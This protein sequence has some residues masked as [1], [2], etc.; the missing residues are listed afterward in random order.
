MIA[1]TVGYIVVLCMLVASVSAYYT[2]ELG[3]FYTSSESITRDQFVASAGSYEACG[4]EQRIIPLWIV[5]KENAKQFRFSLEDAPFASLSGSS[6]TLQP[7]QQGVI[8][9]ILNPSVDASGSAPFYLN[10]NTNGKQTLHHRID[11]VLDQCYGVAVDIESPETILCSCEETTFPVKITNTGSSS[12]SFKVDLNA[13]DFVSIDGDTQAIAAHNTTQNEVIVTPSCDD[14]GSYIIKAIAELERSSSVQGQD[15]IL[16]KI[17]S[18]ESCYNAN[19]DAYNIHAQY[20]KSFQSVTIK[21]SGLKEATYSLSLDA[22]DWIT[23]DTESLRLLPGQIK[24]VTLE[25]NPPSEI[26]AGDYPAKITASTGD[27]VFEEVFTIGLRQETSFLQQV[28]SFLDYYRYYIYIALSLAL[29]GIIL[30]L[31]KRT[32]GTRTEKKKSE[33]MPEIKKKLPQKKKMPTTSRFYISAAIL[34]LG[35]F[36]VYA[37]VRYFDVLKS[38]AK[39]Y[40]GYLLSGLGILIIIIILGLLLKRKK[41]KSHPKSFKKI[42][43]ILLM[44]AVLAAGVYALFYFKLMEPIVEFVMLY[45]TYILVGVGILIVLFLILMFG[46]KLI[47]LFR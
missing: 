31:L 23:V 20:K 10:V 21:N 45:L 8:F 15:S 40:L 6:F 32:K 47:A 25:I 42:G 29:A 34:I 37:I 17:A 22:P 4:G 7:D 13:P 39:D 3:E 14:Q 33:S 41:S 38:F 19:L 24:K 35:A 11:L 12:E 5:N 30:F 18:R 28:S 27:V 43:I 9:I 36:A 44:I 16:I 46:K 2:V 26:G 1:K